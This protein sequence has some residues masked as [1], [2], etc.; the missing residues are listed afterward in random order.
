MSRF[1]NGARYLGEY[2]D[3]RKHGKG[4]F[5][6]PDGS[7]YEGYW[8]DDKRNGYGSYYYI[9]G[10]TYEGEWRDHVRHGKGTYH[11]AASGCKYIGVWR[12]GKM[13]GAGE[14]INHKFRFTGNWRKGQVI[15]LL[16]T[17][18]KLY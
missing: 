14:V 7:R 3:N 6:Y 9:N 8:V 4:T 11:F 16:L 13:D 17:S 18:Y 5:Y 1:K 15:S 12:N 2:L 10:D